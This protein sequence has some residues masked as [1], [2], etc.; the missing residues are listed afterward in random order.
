VLQG[1]AT[2]PNSDT[3]SYQWDE[4]DAGGEVVEGNATDEESLGTDLGGNPLFRSFMPVSAPIRVLPRLSSLVAGTDDKAEVLPT[5]SRALHFRLTARDGQS[6]VGEDD[7]QV[8]VIDSAGP[9]SIK[10][11]ITNNLVADQPIWIEWN[12]ASTELFPINCSNVDIHLLAFSADKGTYCESTLVEGT[13]NIG[14]YRW[15]VPPGLGT[16]SGRIRVSCS[17][18]IFFDISDSDLTIRDLVQMETDCISTDGTPLL[19]GTV[20]NDAGDNLRDLP[21]SSGGGGGGGLS[22][23]VL[24]LGA[25]WSLWLSLGSRGRSRHH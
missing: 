8:E 16:D 15:T 6:G 22:W 25:A 13:P 9:F 14:S 20:F 1:S 18:N 7:M 21:T 24:L 17:D 3:L 10:E 2:D 23:L 12:V 19:Q 11:P 5:T 4:M